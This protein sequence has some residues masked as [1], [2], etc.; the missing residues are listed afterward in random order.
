MGKAYQGALQLQGTSFISSCMCLALC[1]D[2]GS[3]L[4]LAASTSILTAADAQCRRRLR[5]L[6]LRHTAKVNG[7][8]ECPDHQSRTKT[9]PRQEALETDIP[10]RTSGGSELRSGPLEA[11]EKQ[12]FLGADIH[13]PKVRTSMTLRGF[14]K[15]SFAISCV[16]CR[17]QNPSDPQNTPQNKPRSLSRNQ[18]TKKITKNIQKI[19]ILVIF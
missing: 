11:L 10:T 2:V 6:A 12:A 13:D 9:Q 4:A 16:P 18:T 7:Q 8:P 17:I 15:T 19:G 3:I 1:S 5:H 14:Q